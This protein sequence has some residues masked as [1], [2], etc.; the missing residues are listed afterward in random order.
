L[1]SPAAIRVSVVAVV[2]VVFAAVGA[3]LLFANQG[4][5]SQRRTFDLRV[6][7]SQMTPGI[8][9]ANEGD[10]LTLS[11]QADRTEDIHLHGYD[12]HFFA[13]PAPAS[14][15]FAANRTGNFVMEIE[16]TS[17]PVGTLQVQPRGGLLGIGRSADQ[18]S[19][20]VVK[21]P[22]AGIT[23][24][25]STSSWNLSL[26]VG[27]MEPMYTPAQQA[28]LHPRL[29]EVMFSG[30]MVMPPGMADMVSMAGMSAPGWYHMEVHFYDR[31]TGY[32]VRGLDPVITGTDTASG[33]AQT[34]PIVTMQ[35]INE[36]ARD[37]HYGNNIQLP[38]GRY[39]V[40]AVADG[41]TGAFDITV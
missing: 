36:G 13:G 4:P 23:Q 11:I 2:V 26:E 6:A 37:Y 35:G 29:G 17:T 7:G 19:T 14:L 33:K 24:V 10:T 34:L 18:S 15:T 22:F 41:Q 5:A 25:G 21:N 38:S 27:P 39:R 20:T 40:T 12:I 16:A 32:P 9:H 31:T 8:V 3:A 28:S 1:L 30:R